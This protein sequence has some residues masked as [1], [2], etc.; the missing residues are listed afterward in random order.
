MNTKLA[1]RRAMMTRSL[2]A[3]AVALPASQA[4]ASAESAWPGGYRVAF[5][6]SD[7]DPRK[8]T[9]TLNNVRNAQKELGAEHVVAEIVVYGPGIDMLRAG[10]EVAAQ[11]KDAL[12]AKIAVLACENT[13]RG[14]ELK[15]ADMLPDIGY[16]PSGVGEL[17]RR[18]AE[19]YGYIRA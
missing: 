15:H 3:A 18:Q 2:A 17:I 9:L 4:L 6:V 7:A 8:W 5:Q 14:R 12:Q 13:M 1:S 16:V 19:G 11:V 10:S